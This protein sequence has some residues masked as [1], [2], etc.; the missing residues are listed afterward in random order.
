MPNNNKKQS[1]HKG[2]QIIAPS[3]YI[4]INNDIESKKINKKQP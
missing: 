1:N 2:K 4:N 3:V